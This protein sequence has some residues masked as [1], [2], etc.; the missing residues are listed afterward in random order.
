MKDVEIEGHLLGSVRL[1]GED[2]GYMEVESYRVDS[3]DGKYVNITH[4]FLGD[5]RYK[6]QISWR[7]NPTVRTEMTEKTKAF[8][9]EHL[10]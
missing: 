3:S 8:I 1:C 10:S 7:D 4:S 2:S 6:V 9:A 5:N